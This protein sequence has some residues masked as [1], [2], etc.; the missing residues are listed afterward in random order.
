MNHKIILT[1]LLVLLC[2]GCGHTDPDDLQGTWKIDSIRTFYNG[3]TMSTT[4]AG[5]EPVHHYEPDGK[6]R[7]TQGTEFRYFLYTIRQDTLTYLTMQNKPLEVLTIVELN[8]THMV[9]QKE[10]KPLFNTKE[11]RRYEMRYYSKVNE[12]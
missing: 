11:Q 3:F 4:A 10:K 1:A 6:L 12:K 5:D 8:A 2:A 9:L 7:M